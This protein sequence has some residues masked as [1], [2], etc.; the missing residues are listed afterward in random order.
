MSA[1]YP[2][3]TGC[4]KPWQHAQYTTCDRCRN[5]QHI[6]SNIGSDRCSRCRKSW[7]Q[8]RYK[9]CDDCRAY[10][11]TYKRKRSSSVNPRD[12][13]SEPVS[14]SI[15]NDAITIPHFSAPPT[16]SQAWWTRLVQNKVI[17]FS[18]E[19][20]RVCSFCGIGLLSTEANGWCCNNGRTH[21]PQLPSCDGLLKSLLKLCPRQLSHLSRRLNNLFAFSAIGVAGRFVRFQGPANVAIEGRVYHRLIDVANNGHSMHWFLYDEASRLERGRELEIP[22]AV[23]ETV[24]EFLETS[25]PYVH[26][27]R[28]AV[29]E[30]DNDTTPLTIELSIPPGGQEIAAI[31][32]TDNLRHVTPRK[33]AFFRHGGQ[34]PR[35]VPILS[36]QYEPLQYPLL[37]PHGTLGWGCTESSQRYLPCTQIQWYRHLLLTEPRF[38]VLGRLACEYIVDMFS[39]AEEERLSYLREGRRMQSTSMRMEEAA[40][41]TIPDIFENKIPASFMG[42]RAWASDQVADALAIA[43]GLGKPS[44]WL[45]MTTNPRWPEI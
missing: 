9:T 26:T 5:S 13:Q 17:P 4:W 44:M 21:L 14:A 22:D 35:F 23:I 41:S 25:N 30:I 38:N 40:D 27:L 1:S 42:S 36:P 12:S 18:Q 11:R 43:K 16:S 45:T 6:E 31:I 37:F 8:V 32:N 15:S 33:I 34:Q 24:R 28:R 7:Q 19:W 20:S 2:V 29:T 10:A 3:C 39:R